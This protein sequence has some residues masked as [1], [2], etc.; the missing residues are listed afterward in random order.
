MTNLVPIGFLL[1]SQPGPRNAPFLSQALAR[2]ISMTRSAQQQRWNRP[3][4]PWSV[5]LV[6]RFVAEALPRGLPRMERE[7]WQ[8]E[9]PSQLPL[10]GEACSPFSEE[11]PRV[12]QTF[13]E[14]ITGISPRVTRRSG[15]GKTDRRCTSARIGRCGGCTVPASTSRMPPQ[16]TQVE[17][18]R[19]SWMFAHVVQRTAREGLVRRHPRDLGASWSWPSTRRGG[20]PRGRHPER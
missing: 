13:S 8:A 1:E 12:S 17:R 9:S 7:F 2:V 15:S 19:S 5:A 14:E 16:D 3:G 11:G 20:A 6:H 18:R 10:L 4:C